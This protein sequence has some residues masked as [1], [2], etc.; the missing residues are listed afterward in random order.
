[1]QKPSDQRYAYLF[2]YT[3]KRNDLT[4][5]VITCIKIIENMQQHFENMPLCSTDNLN[6]VSILP[7]IEPYPY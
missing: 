5:N 4:D 2:R 7:D 1:M 3:L 6:D